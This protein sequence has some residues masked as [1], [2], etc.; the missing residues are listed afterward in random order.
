M[1]HIRSGDYY[2]VLLA[3][4]IAGLM[5]LPGSALAATTTINNIREGQHPEY[6]RI[7]FDCSGEEPD[8]IG[9]AHAEFMP[10]LFADIVVSIDADQ[11]SDTLGGAVKKIGLHPDKGRTEIRLNFKTPG[12]RV[13]SLII[14]S[15]ENSGRNYRL[16]LDIYTGPLA[17]REVVAPV[18]AATAVAAVPAAVALESTV[19][20]AT[21][22]SS[23]LPEPL[24]IAT[25]AKSS[26]SNIPASPA[27]EAAVS[28]QPPLVDEGNTVE[29]EPD[30]G[31]Q[32]ASDLVVSGEASLVLRATDVDG[33][34]AQFQ[35]YRDL[36][37][38]VTGDLVLDVEKNRDYYMHGKATNIGQDDQFVGAEGGRYGKYGIDITWN[39]FINRYATDARTLYSGVGSDYMRLDDNLQA[40]I[41]SAPND[42]EVANRL[43]GF[44]PSADVGDPENSRD[45]RKI[46]FDLLSLDPFS[47]RVDLASEKREGVRP[48][49]GAFNNAQMVELFEPIDYDTNDVK[50]SGEY[51]QGPYF[52]NLSY[53]FSQFK[54]N[55]D[56]LRFDN[57]LRVSDAVGGPA[58]GRTDLAPDN[59]YH[60]FSASG[61][62][63]QLPWRSQIT[64][65]AAWGRM[66]QDDALLPYTTNT[67]I[68]APAL[69][70]DRVD[71]QVNTSLYNFRLTSRPLSYMRIKGFFR[72]YDY[73]NRT[74]VIGFPDGYVETDD[75]LVSTAVRNL[76]SS[77][78][79]TRAGGNVG[80]DVFSR[81]HLNFGYTYEKTER[82]NREVANQEDHI[83]KASF[84]TRA[85]DWLDLRTAYTRTQRDIGEYRYDIYLESGQD[86]QQLPQ[87]RKYD[88]ADLTR[89]LVEV[90]ATVY[91]SDTLALSG[92]VGY[93]TD[94]F[95]DS[96][97][98][99][100][101]DTRYV[102]SLDGDYALGDRLSLNLFYT[103]EIYEN[104]QRA[105]QNGGAT[106]F[107]WTADGKDL[108]DTLGGGFKLA[109]IPDLLDLD[110]IYAYSEVDGNLEFSSPSGSYDD[111]SA[112]DDTKTHMLNTKLIYH[113]TFLDFDVALGYLWEKFDYTDFAA[114]G[115]SYV[116][117]DTAGN[118]QGALLAGTLPQDYDAH[119]IY[120][121]ITFRYR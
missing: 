80:F 95:H 43:R 75:A 107:D 102:F 115:F 41:Q 46:G 4:L 121:R 68:T 119:V 56:S 12:A 45:Q 25:A 100:I 32:E 86:L 3:L 101:D 50:I 71:A 13:K 105:M 39:K 64:A 61:A 51:A 96:P 114:E 79:K 87:L 109:L 72:Y 66:T 37:Q 77:Y 59:Q 88:E 52:F 112:V 93:G 48:Y 17:T 31:D 7:V 44:I 58:S 14:P 60:N 26:G 103:H 23:T 5:I 83:L 92:S 110:L 22:I 19:V 57:P 120:T 33:S 84:D 90:L 106:D 65:N 67:A 6:T 116:P 20:T 81:S 35:K 16:V 27:V 38:S 29:P 78:T 10:V 94:D 108:V 8:R 21:S 117:T 54:N 118:Y 11:V 53:V 24:F 28:N 36:T 74:G 63:T 69:P 42:V 55:V 76:P 73:D 40:D 34:E 18:T 15:N 30:E 104:E 89:D 99:L 49:A 91:P 62:L 113:N 97:Y 70:A 85:L 47:L 98:G 82:E 2:R 1:K 111:F 9:P